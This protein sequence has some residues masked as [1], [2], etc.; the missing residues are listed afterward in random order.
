MSP[1]G[2]TADAQSAAGRAPR[3]AS[4]FAP[5]PPT[6]RKRV[7]QP[8]LVRVKARGL[9]DGRPAR[10]IGRQA[11]EWAAR[12]MPSTRARIF[13]TLTRRIGAPSDVRLPDG[14]T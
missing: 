1:T 11:R 8:P 14:R 10:A 4:A 13:S 7:A 3:Q 6:Y 2:P 9:H 5:V 12:Q